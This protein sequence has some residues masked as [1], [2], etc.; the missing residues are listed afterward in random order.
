MDFDD[1]KILFIFDSSLSQ[2]Y[3]FFVLSFY[4]LFFLGN[5]DVAW[6]F[7]CYW[8]FCRCSFTND[9]QCSK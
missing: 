9:R 3:N 7:G 8:D 6:W 4:F 5:T 1:K 2:K